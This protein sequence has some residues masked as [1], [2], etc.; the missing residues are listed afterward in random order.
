MHK[1]GYIRVSTR[2]QNIARQL[3]AMRAEGLSIKDLFIDRESGKDFNRP[4][5]RHMVRKL[6]EGDILI[7]K[8]IDR[9]GRDYDMIGTEWKRITQDIKADIKVLDMPLLDTSARLMP[10]LEGRLIA[11]LAFQ[12]FSYVAQKERENIRERQAEGI[13]LAKERGVRFGRPRL[14]I[15]NVEPVLELYL[16][17]GCTRRQALEALKISQ[18]TFYR[19]LGDRRKI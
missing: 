4:M 13:R 9:L 1:Y 2:E 14:V 18:G 8:S 10:G 17:G 16:S 15:P 3:D 12:I 19:L 11:D 6:R 5:Y 7:I